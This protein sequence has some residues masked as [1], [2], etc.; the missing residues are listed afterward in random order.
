M[1]T[2]ALLICGLLACGGGG[3]GGD[4]AGSGS[5]AV[6]CVPPG[7]E[8]NSKGVGKYCTRGGFQ[9]PA[10]G[11]A[12]FCTVD[13]QADAPPFCTNQCGSDD[14]CGE[15]AVCTSDDS[16]RFGCTPT[17]CVPSEMPEPS[18]SPPDAGVS[19]ACQALARCCA[20]PDFP[21][22]SLSFCQARANGGST[23]CGVWRKTFELAGDCPKQN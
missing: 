10:F 17:A 21:S 5:E 19:A 11:F 20:A 7:A 2:C 18:P 8:G 15:D 9:C 12:K 3:G 16:G 23:W 13:F 14:D 1:R 22:K 6:S 4:S